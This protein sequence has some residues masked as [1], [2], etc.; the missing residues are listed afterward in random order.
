MRSL[1]SDITG[2]KGEGIASLYSVP[3]ESLQIILAHRRVAVV[4]VE[5]VHVSGPE[6]GSFIHP[7]GGA[8][9]PFLY[10]VQVWLGGAVGEVVLGMVE[11]VD[12]G[13]LHV[14]GAL[15]GGEKV[16]RR[17]VDRPVAIP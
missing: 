2:V 7:P 8:V 1:D 11:H 15:G 6:P 10:L 4:R 14:P 17:S 13:L 5:D 12:G 9:G 16:G 3:L